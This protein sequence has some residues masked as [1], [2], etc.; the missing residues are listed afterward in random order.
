MLVGAGRF[1]VGVAGGSTTDSAV[2]ERGGRNAE[3]ESG[4][5]TTFDEWVFK[6]DAASVNAR[7]RLRAGCSGEAGD[8]GTSV[9]RFSMLA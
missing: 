2:F 5:D 4:G 9:A 8:G 6:E 7:L 3:G 1:E